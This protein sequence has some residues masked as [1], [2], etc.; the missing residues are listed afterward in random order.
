MADLTVSVDFTFPPNEVFVFFVPQR[1]PLWYGTE[2]DPC[3][4]V[5]GGAADF[6]VGQKGRITGKLQKREVILTVVIT[7][8]DWNRLLEWQFQDIYGV[9]GMQ[10]WEL[11]KMAG[12]TRLVMQDR[13]E[14]PGRLGRIVDRC[15]TR[16]AV[17]MRDRAW[18]KRL[19]KLVGTR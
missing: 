15:L 8:Y 1:M 18:L 2:M 14:M 6:A 4:E 11:H 3:F 17:A 5:Q 12:A 10:R 16:H 9:R 13:Y 7:A 19:Q